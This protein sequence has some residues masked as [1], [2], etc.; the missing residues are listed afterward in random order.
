MAGEIAK[1][2]SFLIRP[3]VSAHRL[4]GRRRSRRSGTIARRSPSVRQRQ[5]FTLIELLVVIAVIALLLAILIPV[6]RSAREQAQRV[7]CL[8]NLRQLTLAWIL[9]ADDNDGKIVYG[10]V[11]WDRMNDGRQAVRGWLGMSDLLDE[12]RDRGALWPYIQDKAVY[13]CP[14]GWRNA[15]VTYQIVDAARG[16]RVEGTYFPVEIPADFDWKVVE[17]RKFG[18][19]VGSTVLRLTRLTDIISPGAAQRAVFIDTGA[20]AGYPFYI[21]YLYPRWDSPSPPPL[22]H[23]DGTTLSMADGHV[24]YWKWGRETL[25]MPRWVQYGGQYGGNY[26]GG[27]DPFYQ[28][29][30]QLEADY[31]PQTEDGKYDLQR[32]QRATWGRLGY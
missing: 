2:N 7:V 3:I 21:H 22:H 8:S 15:V 29:D 14:R 18:K 26:L 9:Y 6:L 13:R 30:E 17:Y 16:Y 19:R 4:A 23:R 20:H 10:G 28:R 5:A 31:E 25:K 24:E 32:L 1:R 12:D 27:G 11:G